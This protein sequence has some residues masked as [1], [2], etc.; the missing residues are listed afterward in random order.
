MQPH[1][2]AQPVVDPKVAELQQLQ[3][4]QQLKEE[5]GELHVALTQAANDFKLLKEANEG[6]TE[7]LV[8]ALKNQKLAAPPSD[9]SD[10]SEGDSVTYVNHAGIHEPATVTGITGEGLNLAVQGKHANDK[11]AVNDVPRGATK[12]RNSFHGHV[13]KAKA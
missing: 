7:K 2:P 9:F 6:L 10:I 11:Y 8:A 3:Q 13:K 4:L 1:P 5:N 12:A